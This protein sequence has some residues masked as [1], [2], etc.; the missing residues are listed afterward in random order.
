MNYIFPSRL[1]LRLDWSEMDLYGHINNVA[2]AKF[3]QASRVNYWEMAGL[4][5]TM[6]QGK[7]GP[8]LAATEII[9]KKPLYYPG[10]IMVKASV[11]FIKTTSFGIYHEICDENDKVAAVANDVIVLYDYEKNEKTALPLS[12]KE[13]IMR[14]EEKS[15]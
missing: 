12:L 5:S 11:S 13:L 2:Y 3:I 6:Q 15:F 7:T 14:L 1:N 8:T 10:S 9:F 4:D